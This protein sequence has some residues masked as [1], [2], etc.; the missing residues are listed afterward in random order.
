MKLR[1]ALLLMAGALA[2]CRQDM[3]NQPRYKPLAQSEFFA[4]DAA[5]RTPPPH[6]I[7]RGRLE[8]DVVF[9]TG[10]GADGNLAAT[11]PMPVTLDLLKRGQERFTIYCSVCH[12]ASGEGNGMIVRRGFPAP[13]SYHLDRLRQAPPGYLFHVITHGYGA[14]YSYASR[15]PAA[16]RWAIVAYIKALQL[17]HH[18]ELSDAP[19]AERATLE[20]SRR[21]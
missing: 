9:F 1:L 16:D 21:E 5:S 15:V 8:E 10:A 6:T 18:A 14:M 7:A 3:Y 17:S 20:G 19:P 4:D 13:E 11:L 2:G 12:G